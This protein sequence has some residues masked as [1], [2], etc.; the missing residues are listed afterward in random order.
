[1]G[2]VTKKIPTK[3]VSQ[4]IQKISLIFE[5]S[6]KNEI[7]NT[8][9]KKENKVRLMCNSFEE[10]MQN[11]GARRKVY[12]VKKKRKRSVEKVD[13][14]NPMRKSME[15]W[16]VKEKTEKHEVLEFRESRPNSKVVNHDKLEMIGGGKSENL[17]KPT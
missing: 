9:E 4:G 12:E 17:V 3:K 6:E 8:P 1:M 14:E 10:M 5:K 15:N 16:V 7:I 2:E 11:T 13:R